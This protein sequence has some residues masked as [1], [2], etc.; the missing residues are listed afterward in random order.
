MLRIGY[1]LSDDPCC[2]DD[3]RADVCCQ[4]GD[5]ISTRMRSRAVVPAPYLSCFYFL[6]MGMFVDTYLG[7][8]GIGAYERVHAQ[9]NYGCVA[10]VA[11]FFRPICI[12]LEI[13]GLTYATNADLSPNLACYCGKALCS[14]LIYSC[15]VVS[16]LS[17]SCSDDALGWMYD[18]SVNF[19]C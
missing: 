6:L 16:Q 2:S 7:L 4:M 9:R 13:I 8:L 18:T 5:E 3:I 1:R 12:D 19:K 15:F 10:A 17:L 14:G 11:C